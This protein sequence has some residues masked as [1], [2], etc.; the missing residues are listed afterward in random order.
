PRPARALRECEREPWPCRAR[1][2]GPSA[3]P[4]LHNRER[5]R[6]AACARHR[7]ARRAARGYSARASPWASASILRAFAR[8][9]RTQRRLIVG[10]RLV[11]PLASTR[12]TQELTVI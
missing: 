4:S 3:S 8:V 9:C 12:A 6:L 5:L 11:M 7:V 10:G 2:R 1:P